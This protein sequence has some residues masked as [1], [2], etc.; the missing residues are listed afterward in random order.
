MQ[1]LHSR[2]VRPSAVAE[3]HTAAGKAGI[4]IPIFYIIIVIY[5]GSD[6]AG[7]SLFRSGFERLLKVLRRRG[8]TRVATVGTE[9]HSA[10]RVNLAATLSGCDNW[11]SCN[12]N[13]PSL[14]VISIVEG[15]QNDCR[16]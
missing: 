8:E 4:L 16:A 3:S 12:R 13:M 9:I 5:P 7:P 15:Y 11:K 1:V 2:L 10:K 6:D 14:L